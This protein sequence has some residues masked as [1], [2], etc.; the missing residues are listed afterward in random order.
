MDVRVCVNLL[1]GGGISTFFFR[2]LVFVFYGSPLLLSGMD[3]VTLF[4]VDLAPGKRRKVPAVPPT[5]NSP[6][7]PELTK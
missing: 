2:F 4:C 5:I 1:A 7:P 3:L 6:P